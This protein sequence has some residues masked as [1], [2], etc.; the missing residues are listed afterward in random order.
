MISAKEARKNTAKI[1][2]ARAEKEMERVESSIQDAIVNGEHKTLESN[3][4]EQT[5]ARLRDL[6]YTIGYPR[7]GKMAIQ[8]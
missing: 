7:Q 1:S 2:E 6:G 3:L 8:W 4:T 5:K